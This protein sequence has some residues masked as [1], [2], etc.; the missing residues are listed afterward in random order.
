MVSHLIRTEDRLQIEC[1]AVIDFHVRCT[2]GQMERGLW[3]LLSPRAALFLDRSARRWQLVGGCCYAGNVFNLAKKNSNPGVTGGHFPQGP[4]CF[5]T[6]FTWKGLQKITSTT[7]HMF[8]S[9]WKKCCKSENVHKYFKC[10]CSFLS[11]WCK[12][13]KQ[14]K[15]LEQ[16]VWQPFKTESCFVRAQL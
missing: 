10:N 1:A 8:L 4:G 13:S 15:E 2:S 12:V 5:R 9:G 6:Q 3:T 11:V 14:G 16:S 7:V